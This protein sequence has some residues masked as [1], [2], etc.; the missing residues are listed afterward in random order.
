M[1]FQSQI[2]QQEKTV[3]ALRTAGHEH[4]DALRHL[5]EMKDSISLLRGPI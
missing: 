4:S 3:E 5:N 2:S 1:Q